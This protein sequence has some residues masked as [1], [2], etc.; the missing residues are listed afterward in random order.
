M[1][2][3]ISLYRFCHNTNIQKTLF[4]I[5][6]INSPMLLN[7]KLLS[8]ERDV[9]YRMMEVNEIPVFSTRQSDDTEINVRH[10][11]KIGYDSY[12]KTF[13]FSYLM[14]I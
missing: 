7:A 3:V 12:S 10:F 1:A 8:K 2:K 6:T 14:F 9:K 13:I 4:T 5:H 11:L